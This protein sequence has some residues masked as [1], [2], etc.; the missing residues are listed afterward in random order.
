MSAE[1]GRGGLTTLVALALALMV[2]SLPVLFIGG[3]G[4]P[5][6]AADRLGR[7]QEIETRQAH[8]YRQL[9]ES[10]AVLESQRQ[11]YVERFR[12]L[13]AQIRRSD[14]EIAAL[15]ARLTTITTSPDDAIDDI[16]RER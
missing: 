15:R 16:H 14:Q 7:A 4:R 9:V 5:G 2:A 3:A 1:G 6:F 10:D 12:R 13:E 8:L 11:I